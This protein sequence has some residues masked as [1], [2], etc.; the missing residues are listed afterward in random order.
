MKYDNRFLIT[1]ILTMLLHNLIFVSDFSNFKSIEKFSSH[2]RLST[3]LK[4][5]KKVYKVIFFEI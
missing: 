1:L 3:I 5:N 2:K 4:T